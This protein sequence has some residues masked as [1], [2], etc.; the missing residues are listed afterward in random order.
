MQCN[1]LVESFQ[2]LG[3]GRSEGIQFCDNFSEFSFFKFL[4]N[5]LNSCG[6]STAK[7]KTPPYETF[8]H[9]LNGAEHMGLK[10]S[11][12]NHRP[13]MIVNWFLFLK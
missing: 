11:I 5:F 9:P 4:W 13:P 3:R 12:N 7:S 2:V 1:K 8:F 6:C 10:L